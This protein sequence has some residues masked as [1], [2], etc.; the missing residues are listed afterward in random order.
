MSKCRSQL[1]L[2]SMSFWFPWVL[3]KRTLFLLY[4]LSSV[5]YFQMYQPHRTKPVAEKKN[6]QDQVLVDG[7]CEKSILKIIYPK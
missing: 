4:I 7:S 6:V 1:T 5:N 2:L 3:S